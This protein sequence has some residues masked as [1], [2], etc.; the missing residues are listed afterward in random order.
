MWVDFGAMMHVCNN[1][2]QFRTYDEFSIEQQVLIGSH[3]KAK[4]L[5]NGNVKV[6]MSSDKM[7]ILTNVFYVPDIKNNLVSTNLLCKSG[8]KAVLESD[9]LILSKNEIFVGKG[10]ATDDMYKLSII[11]KEV[12]SCAYI[13]DSSYLWHARLGHLNFKYLKFMSK[14]GMISYKHDDEK[15]CEIC[16]QAK[17]TKKPFS[18]LDR[19]SIMLDLVHFNICELNG[20]LTRG[21]KRYFITFID[22]FC[23]FTYVYLMRNKDE[24]FDMFKRY[25]LKQKIKRIRK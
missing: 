16:I 21:G 19:N 2:E 14:H 15:K 12:S 17:M 7:L 1:K 18:K 5:R 11:N 24:S 4:V 22:N 20:V 8:V 10:Y 3:N 13:V 23:R 6:K 25:K 9:K